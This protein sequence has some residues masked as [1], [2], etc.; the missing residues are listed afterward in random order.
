[1]EETKSFV[2]RIVFSCPAIMFAAPFRGQFRTR[3]FA[4]SIMGRRRCGRAGLSDTRRNQPFKGSVCRPHSLNTRG[5]V[6]CWTPSI[7][8]ARRLRSRWWDGDFRANPRVDEACNHWRWFDS[9]PHS[10]VLG[11]MQEADV[12][13]LPSLAEG[14]ALVVLEARACGLPVI[15][16]PNTGLVGVRRRRARGLRW[17]YSQ[18]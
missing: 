15:V 13:V 11:L 9:L 1:M 12:L 14:C 3:E 18:L 4:W 2:L 10:E 7:G 6:T 17:S 8:L 16:T 5:S